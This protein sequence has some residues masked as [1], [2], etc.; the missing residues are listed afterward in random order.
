MNASVELWY[1]PDLLEGFC[2]SQRHC[3]GEVDVRDQRNVIPE[4]D[5]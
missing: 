5:G 3:R 1:T 4:V 2:H